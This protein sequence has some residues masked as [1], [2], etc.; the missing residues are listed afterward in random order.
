[1][2]A[3]VRL[4]AVSEEEAEGVRCLAASQNLPSW[5]SVLVAQRRPRVVMSTVQ[6][7][8]YASQAGERR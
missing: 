2:A 6:C 3:R 4:R 8:Q 1:M 5:S 7:V